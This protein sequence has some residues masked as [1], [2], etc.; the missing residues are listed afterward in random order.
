MWTAPVGP[1]GA[2]L[3]LQET[4]QFIAELQQQ[5]SEC[6]WFEWS[7]RRS[8]DD[9]IQQQ[10]E[11]ATTRRAQ[12][13]EHAAEQVANQLITHDWTRRR[14]ELS[15]RNPFH[16]ESLAHLPEWLPAVVHAARSGHMFEYGPYRR[17]ADGRIWASELPEVMELLTVPYAEQLIRWRVE[18][19]AAI[20]DDPTMYSR[21]ESVDG[22]QVMT[23]QH[24]RSGLRAQFGWGEGETVGKVL[25]KTYK[26]KSIGPEPDHASVAWE[27]YLGL[28]IGG[29]IY[30]AASRLLPG[31]RWGRIGLLS[32]QA[33][34][35]RVRLHGEDP[36]TWSGPCDWCSHRD[37]VSGWW[38][39][40][41]ADFADH[42][43][44]A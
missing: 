30:R 10:Q 27:A 35:L 3:D 5:R 22:G 11:L 18:R 36:W 40:T 17:R 41:N 28:G 7:E 31:M 12:L 38:N 44:S 2:L 32:E 21:L 4:Q 42:P 33:E 13:P 16:R 26:I 29:A 8:L 43:N 1:A 9:W 25:S 15:F 14:R 23:V 19:L 6:G 37:L 34:M 24:A 20:A 39:A